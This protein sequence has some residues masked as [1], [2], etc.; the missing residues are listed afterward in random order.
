MASSE[1]GAEQVTSFPHKYTEVVEVEDLNVLSSESSASTN[2]H[3][4]QRK[5]PSA[6]LLLIDSFLKI[7][8]S[9]RA[10]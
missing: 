8:A 5:N 7:V 6:H 10:I 1:V 2:Q 9:N 4:S 3:P